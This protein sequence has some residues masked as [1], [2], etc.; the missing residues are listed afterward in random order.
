MAFK[1]N[2]PPPATEIDQLPAMKRP[3]LS[4]PSSSKKLGTTE[5]FSDVLVKL[6]ADALSSDYA[7]AQSSFDG[8]AGDRVV[9]GHIETSDAWPRPKLPPWDSKNDKVVFQQIDIEESTDSSSG[10]T[11][12]LFGVT[13]MGNS[14]L[15]HVHGF[16]PYFYVAAPKGFL[17]RDCMG[18]KDKLNVSFSR[19]VTPHTRV[20]TKLKPLNSLA[21]LCI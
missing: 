5:S 9:G 14:V 12:R 21:F 13:K 3:R 8:S 17:E 15:A 16:R 6:E 4:E 11:L 19:P 18:F 2:L 7:P 1:E 10:T 20:K